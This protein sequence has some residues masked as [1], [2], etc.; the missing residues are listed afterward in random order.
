MLIRICWFLSIPVIGVL[1]DSNLTFSFMQIFFSITFLFFLVIQFGVKQTIIPALTIGLML[2]SYFMHTYYS[3]TLINLFIVLP[4]GYFW[5]KH[6]DLKN[7]YLESLSLFMMSLTAAVIKIIE[8]NKF[9]IDTMDLSFIF[10]YL[11]FT[12]IFSTLLGLITLA[13]LDFSAKS[14]KLPHFQTTTT[15]RNN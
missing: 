15:N 1:L 9:H 6:G 4:V 8:V 2:D 14:L 10:I 12:T 13:F 7:I 11:S 5:I 3:N